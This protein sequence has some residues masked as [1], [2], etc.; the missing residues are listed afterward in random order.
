[1][2]IH[3]LGPLVD[4]AELAHEPYEA[5]ILQFLGELRFQRIRVAIKRKKLDQRTC[6]SLPY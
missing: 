4:E 3:I 1:M 5:T 2:T 6:K